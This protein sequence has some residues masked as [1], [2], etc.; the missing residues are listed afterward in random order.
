MRFTAKNLSRGLTFIASVLVLSGFQ[1]LFSQVQERFTDGEFKTNP[2][3]TGDTSKFVVNAGLQLQLNGKQAS[4]T[5]YLSTPSVLVENTEWSFF[6]KMAFSPSNTNYVRIY[7]ASDRPNLKSS[8]NGYYVRIG[9]TGSLDGVDLYR[10]S[11]N[12]SSKIIDGIAGHAA[13]SNTPLHVRVTRDAAGNWNLYCDTLGGNN[14]IHEGAAYDN[15]YGTSVSAGVYCRYSSSNRTKFYFDNIVIKPF[16]E[17][18]V[19][20]L[21]DSVKA[22]GK[23]ALCLYFSEALKKITAENTINYVVLNGPGNPLTARLDSVNPSVVY[24]KFSA[25]FPDDKQ[26][27]LI[28]NGLADT[29]SN[30]QDS[31]IRAY[32]TYS[33]PVV[34]AYGDIVI[35]EI[36]ADPSPAVGLPGAEFIE[37]LNLKS[38]PINLKGWKLTDGSSTA[39][40]KNYIVAPGATPPPIKASGK[41]LA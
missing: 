36:Y 23:N 26:N 9:E 21:L 12:T 6:V 7:L 40:F 41:C 14:F 39:V 31:L 4:D 1:P 32:F 20:P 30:Y 38:K 13:K 19:G 5:A 17:D 3:W 2:P 16:A 37:I 25:S 10:Q 33:Y 29:S 15:T 11:G 28:I 34:P 22:T 24:L 18:T 35:N 8:L 27:T